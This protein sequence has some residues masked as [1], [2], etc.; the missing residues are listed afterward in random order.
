MKKPAPISDGPLRAYA[1]RPPLAPD[2]RWAWRIVYHEGPAQ[3]TAAGRH[4]GRYTAAEVRALLRRLLAEGG[5]RQ[6]AEASAPTAQPTLG[7][8]LD[9]WLEDCERRRDRGRLAERS[10]RAYAGAREHCRALDGVDVRR[11]E[12]LTVQAWVDGLED[13]GLSPSTVRLVWTT[14]GMAWR[15]GRSRRYVPALDLPAPELPS[16][17]TRY[18]Q[19]T[20]TLEEALR[21]HACL[22]GWHRVAVDLL[23]GTGAR[24]GELA[25]LRWQDWRQGQV[26][27][28]GKTGERWVP[29]GAQT[30][31]VLDAWWVER[32]RPTEGPVWPV[33]YAGAQLARLLQRACRQAGVPIYTPHGLRRLASTRLIAGDADPVSYAALMGHSYQMGLRTYAEVVGERLEATAALLDPGAGTVVD[34]GAERRR[35]G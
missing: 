17:A 16:P 28:D 12:L 33:A 1:H 21:V 30:A 32:G 19:T 7:T 10:L 20:P 6:P 2:T 8:L 31:A 27:L 9:L 4:G 24:V 23:L 29:L 25:A 26:R 3:H 14:L 5:W 18:N 15:W 35:R 11:V 34:L 13:R 22:S